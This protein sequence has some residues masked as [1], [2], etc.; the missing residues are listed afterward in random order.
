MAKDLREEIKEYYQNS[1]LTSTQ[2]AEKLGISRQMLYYHLDKKSVD[3]VIQIEE[4][5][6]IPVGYIS[7]MVMYDRLEE[8]KTKLN[9][10]R[11][12]KEIQLNEVV[13]DIKAIEKEQIR[14]LDKKQMKLFN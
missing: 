10:K 1:G 6:G 9:A 7:D 13:R 5:L 3:I 4:I 14:I 11:K 2:L 8:Q 12:K